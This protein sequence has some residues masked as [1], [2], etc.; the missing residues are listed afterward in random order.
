M[1]KMSTACSTHTL[2]ISSQLGKL[3]MI[4]WATSRGFTFF[5]SFFNSCTFHTS[6]TIINYKELECGPMPSVMVALPNTGGTLCS[7]PQSMADAHYNM[8]CSNDAKTRNQLKFGG[9]PKLTKRSQ[10]LVS[11]SSPYC[12]YIWRTYCCLTSFSCK[13]IAR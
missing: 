9:R 10:P 7:T 13:D 3:S 2:P 11:R 1:K 4:F 6:N 5:S 8:P 12:G